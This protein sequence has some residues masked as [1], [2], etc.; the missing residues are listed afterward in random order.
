M[1]RGIQQWLI[2]TALQ[3]RLAEQP[4]SDMT[5]FL[6]KGR[7]SVHFIELCHQTFKSPDTLIWPLKSVSPYQAFV[8][9]ALAPADRQGQPMH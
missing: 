6:P 1:L 4:V 5:C 7:E 9:Q 3:K 2:I 8:S